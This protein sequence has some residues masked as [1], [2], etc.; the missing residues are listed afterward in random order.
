[1]A[2]GGEVRAG[3]I[4]LEK[5]EKKIGK[6]CARFTSQEGSREKRVGRGLLPIHPS[7]VY[8]SINETGEGI[9]TFLLTCRK[10]K[11]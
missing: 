5:I 11:A 8:M 1:M 7:Y 9:K 6:V 2:G 3:G 10:C 4:S